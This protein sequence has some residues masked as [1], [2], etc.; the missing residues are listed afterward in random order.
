MH[1]TVQLRN[2]KGIYCTRANITF[3]PSGMKKSKKRFRNGNGTDMK[4][5]Q[6]GLKWLRLNVY[7]GLRS[8]GGL[9]KFVSNLSQMRP[10][11]YTE[12]PTPRKLCHFLLMDCLLS[13]RGEQQNNNNNNSNNNNNNTNA[14][15]CFQLRAPLI[16]IVALCV[17][18]KTLF[19]TWRIG[20]YR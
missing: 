5:S 14:N 7:P 9:N 19:F 3:C 13:I 12:T 18:T 2:T 6:N 20:P 16:R 11:K 15:C 10:P 4:R 8:Y 1:F 17:D